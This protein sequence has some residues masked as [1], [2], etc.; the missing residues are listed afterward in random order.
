MIS[1]VVFTAV[2]SIEFCVILL[3]ECWSLK[4]SLDYEKSL[5]EFK[6]W[7]LEQYMKNYLES[8]EDADDEK[9]HWT[10]NNKRNTY[11]RW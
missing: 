4:R 2:V 9:Q 6:E 10:S 3:V 8:Y 1:D 11:K 5:R 7:I